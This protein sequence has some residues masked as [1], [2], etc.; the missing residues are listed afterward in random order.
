MKKIIGLFLA[1]ILCCLFAQSALALP[2][3]VYLVNINTS[4]SGGPFAVYDYTEGFQGDFLFNTFCLETDEYVNLPGAY[5]ATY[6]S[7]AIDGGSGGDSPDPLNQETAWI[8]Q[9]WSNGN[10]LGWDDYEVQKAIWYWE[11]E[12][13]GVYNS[14]AQLAEGKI[15]IAQVMNLWANSDF[16]GL[17]QSQIAPVPEPGTILLLGL[18]LIGI[19]GAG[20]KKLFKK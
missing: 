15:G 16:T 2:S 4:T 17:K 10:S 8:Y 14:I 13:D 3:R 18:G 5:Y 19:A 9:T 11:D 1:A 20:R 6:G 12:V 7:A